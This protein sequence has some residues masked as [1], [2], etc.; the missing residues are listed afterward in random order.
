MS[1]DAHPPLVASRREWPRRLLAAVF[2]FPI[3]VGWLVLSGAMGGVLRLLDLGFETAA[4]WDV[5]AFATVVLPVILTFALMEASPSHATPG[6]RR[7]GLEVVDRDGARLTRGRSFARS[8]VK[9][10]PWQ[11][12]HTA[13]FQLLSGN[14]AVGYAVLAAIAQVLAVA[15]IIT[16]GI[17]AR[18]RSFHDFLAGTQIVHDEG[19]DEAALAA[20]TFRWKRR[21]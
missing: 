16:M 21:R 3:I 6:K 12:A 8:A 1:T 5:Y 4:A 11:M 9:F 20:S 2:D 7:L 15:S 18:H 10:A 19:G 14:T 13:V 17:D